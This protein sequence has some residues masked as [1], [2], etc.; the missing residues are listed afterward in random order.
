[1]HFLNAPSI[2]RNISIS[3]VSIEVSDKCLKAFAILPILTI[4]LVAAPL[5]HATIERRIA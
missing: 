3:S 2:C 5:V 4:I 1:M